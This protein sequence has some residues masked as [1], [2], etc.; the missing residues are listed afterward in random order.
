MPGTNVDAVHARRPRRASAWPATVSWSVTANIAHAGG[1]HAAHQLRRAAPAVG[2]GRVQVQVDHVVGRGLAAAPPAAVPASATW[3]VGAGQAPRDERAVL[4]NQQLEV[5]ALLVGELEE[6]LLALGVLEPLAVALEERCEPRSQR[7]PMRSAS[8]SSTPG[9]RSSLGAL[10]EQ[11]VGGAL[12]EQERRP[13]FELGIALEQRAVARLEAFEVI[14]SS[15]ASFS[16][17]CRPAAC[18]SPAWRRGCRTR[19]RCARWRWR[20]AARRARTAAPSCRPR[21]AAA[22]PVWQASQVP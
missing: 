15:A 17:T 12:E 22:R 13:R 20:C 14:A 18:S 7:M 8:A 2:G 3:P 9:L 10:G 4:A 5:L 1:V 16:N 21:A 19:G 6:D 11:A